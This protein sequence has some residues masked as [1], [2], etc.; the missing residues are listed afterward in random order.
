MMPTRQPPPRRV[1]TVWWSM[2]PRSNT[3]R[4]QGCSKGW[5]IQQVVPWPRL[6]TRL[7]VPVLIVFGANDPFG[8]PG[9]EETRDAFSQVKPTMEIIQ[10]CGHM[11]W[12]EQ[13]QTFYRVIHD[14]L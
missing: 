4:L 2:P 12:V 11:P 1:P 7:S 10:Q 8:I 3:R 13:P 6:T 14:F 5:P 9:A